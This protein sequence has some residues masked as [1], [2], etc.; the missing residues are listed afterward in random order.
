MASLLSRLAEQTAEVYRHLEV[1]AGALLAR[2]ERPQAGPWLVFNRADLAAA[3][4]HLVREAFPLA[5]EGEGWPLR[6]MGFKEWDRVAGLVWA[7]ARAA[8]LPGGVHA[9]CRQRVVLV[10]KK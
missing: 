6:G 3:P 5:W 7:E 2:A 4:R 9:R 10:G 1:S 8:D